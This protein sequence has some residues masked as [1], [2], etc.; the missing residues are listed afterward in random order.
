MCTLCQLQ[1]SLLKVVWYN[2]LKGF[3]NISKTLVSNIKNSLISKVFKINQI[4]QFT[5]VSEK[6]NF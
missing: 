4:N 1:I 3:P 6:K 5:L 2:F